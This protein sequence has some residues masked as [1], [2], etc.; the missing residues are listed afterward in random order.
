MADSPTIGGGQAPRRPRKALRRL[1]TALAIVGAALLVW[2]AVVYFWQEPFTGVYA[3]YQ[4]GRL[5][6]E[7]E[8]RV[9]GEPLPPE[10]AAATNPAQLQ[11]AIAR[12]A[13][14]YRTSLA[15]GAAMGRLF[16][17][18]L[19]LERIVI[20]GAEVSDLRTGPGRDLR[21]FM[22]GE[23]ELVYI[24]GHRTTYGA[25]FRHI[26]DLRPGDR[27]VLEVPY[28]RF[29][30]RVTGHAVVLPSDVDR[31]R[32]RGREELHLQASHPP[33]SAAR[34]YVVSARFVG[35]EPLGE[36]AEARGR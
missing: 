14:A 33:Y 35:V 18:R 20:N 30:Y 19:D 11:R 22:P 17:P 21:T 13:R 12:A 7:Y 10:D 24:A 8:K 23:S 6:R 29:E 15:H 9:A 1:G 32:S 2:A 27:I 36:A 28:G 5:E 16:V 26:D 25:P 31:L 34:R 4:Q 3:D